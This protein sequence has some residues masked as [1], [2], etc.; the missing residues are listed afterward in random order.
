MHIIS[1]IQSKFYCSRL[2]YVYTFIRYLGIASLTG[3][4]PSLASWSDSTVY[5]G[6]TVPLIKN[7]MLMVLVLSHRYL[8]SGSH[9]KGWGWNC[10]FGPAEHTGQCLLLGKYIRYV[11]MSLGSLSKPTTPQ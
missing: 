9:W 3:R 8:A 5:L 10:C 7:S 6:T 4:L 1:V 11:N 2:P